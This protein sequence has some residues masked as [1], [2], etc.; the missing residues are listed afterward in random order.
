MA[1]QHEES[2][3]AH[4]RIQVLFKEYDALRSSIIGRT[5]NGYQLWGIGAALLTYLMSRPIDLKFWLLMVLFGLVFGAFS[6]TTIRDINK[7]AER[8]RELESSINGLAGGELLQWE[9]RWGSGVTGYLGRARPL[10]Q[11]SHFQTLSI[12]P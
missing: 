12:G 7:A 2:V 6:W 10:K 8:L 1:D 11:D 4:E 5:S 3:G 9:T